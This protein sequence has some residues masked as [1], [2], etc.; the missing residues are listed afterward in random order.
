MTE[1]H[2]SFLR[3]PLAVRVSIV[4]NL[5]RLG[6]SNFGCG[7]RQRALGAPLDLVAAA[8]HDK[9]GSAAALVSFTVDTLLDSVIHDLALGY[10]RCCT[11]ARLAMGELCEC[12]TERTLG[13]CAGQGHAGRQDALDGWNVHRGV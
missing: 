8:F 13:Q 10:H 2:L 7:V 4:D 3:H 1:A 5:T 11:G 6:V 12:A 9:E